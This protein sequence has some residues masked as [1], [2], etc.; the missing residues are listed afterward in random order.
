MQI[1]PSR[2][3]VNLIALCDIEKNE[4]ILI[5]YLDDDELEDL[6]L[7]RKVWHSVGSAAQLLLVTAR[8]LQFCLWVCSM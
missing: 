6:T 5:S 3:C 2:A 1:T 8:R 4:E 7:R